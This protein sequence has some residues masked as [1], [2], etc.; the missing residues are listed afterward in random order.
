MN[1]KIPILTLIDTPES[2]KKN[3][4]EIERKPHLGLRCRRLLASPSVYLK[5]P[6]EIRNSAPACAP[7]SPWNSQKSGLARRLQLKRRRRGGGGGGRTRRTRCRRNESR[8]ARGRKREKKWKQQVRAR[9]C[10]LLYGR[11]TIHTS[12]LPCSEASHIY[13]YT[14]THV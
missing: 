11:R 7:L 5:Y 2:N 13:R 3:K 4:K 6:P 14:Y 9:R 10:T 1:F 12:A 8:S